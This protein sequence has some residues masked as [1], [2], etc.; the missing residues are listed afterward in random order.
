MK[1]ITLCLVRKV[2]RLGGSPLATSQLCARPLEK[3]VIRQLVNP[4]NQQINFFERVDLFA[5]NGYF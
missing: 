2:F 3:N 4:L 5:Y 1:L